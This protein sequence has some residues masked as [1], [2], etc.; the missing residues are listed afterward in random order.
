M[1]QT[2][3]NVRPLPPLS[4]AKLLDILA[5]LTASA[6]PMQEKAHERA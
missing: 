5:A 4:A 3:T 1:S 6:Q 2:L